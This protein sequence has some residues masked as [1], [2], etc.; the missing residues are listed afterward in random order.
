VAATSEARA[1]GRS[2]LVGGRR[3]RHRPG[4]EVGERSGP[5][6]SAG[7]VEEEHV[8]LARALR[9]ARRGVDELVRL[10]PPAEVE[11]FLPEGRDPRGARSTT[12]RTVDGGATA[13]DAA[14]RGP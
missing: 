9:R 8:R 7:T 14:G 10:L 13:E 4:G 2:G 11:L 6:R 3:N 5:P 12:V 1:R